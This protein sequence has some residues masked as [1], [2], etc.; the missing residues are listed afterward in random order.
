MDELNLDQVPQDINKEFQFESVHL[1]AFVAA[2][3][4]SYKNNSLASQRLYSLPPPTNERAPPELSA[5]PKLPRH[6]DNLKPRLPDSTVA[7]NSLHTTPQTEKFNESQ[8]PH[9]IL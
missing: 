6:E 5:M 9:Q 7:A 3:D 8:P 4:P 1:Q 2:A